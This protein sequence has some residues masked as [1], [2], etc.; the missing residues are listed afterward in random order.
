[1]SEPQRDLERP[2]AVM[3]GPSYDVGSVAIPN[4]NEQS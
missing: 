3:D 1:M 2:S 4:A